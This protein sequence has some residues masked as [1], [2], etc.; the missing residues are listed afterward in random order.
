MDH[1]CLNKETAAFSGG[2]C[3][4]GRDWGR[5]HEGETRVVQKTTGKSGTGPKVVRL[6][7]G[8]GWM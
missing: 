6:A 8:G 1:D 4:R 5:S 3:K 7:G 2:K